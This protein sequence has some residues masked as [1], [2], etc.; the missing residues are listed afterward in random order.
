MFLLSSKCHGTKS[1]LISINIVKNKKHLQKFIFLMC[2][3][4]LPR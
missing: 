4:R 3:T 2:R 1:V